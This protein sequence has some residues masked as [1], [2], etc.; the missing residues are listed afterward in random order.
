MLFLFSLQLT[1]MQKLL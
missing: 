1:L